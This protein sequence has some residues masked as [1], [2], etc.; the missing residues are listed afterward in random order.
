MK[1]KD[2]ITN[3]IKRIINEN[4]SDKKELKAQKNI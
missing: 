4:N 3:D 1:L 2:L